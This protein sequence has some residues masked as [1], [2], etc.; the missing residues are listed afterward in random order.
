M[1]QLF[2]IAPLKGLIDI[3][4]WLYKVTQCPFKELINGDTQFSLVKVSKGEY[5]RLSTH[6]FPQNSACV[7]TV[8]PRILKNSGCRVQSDVLT[9]VCISRGFPLP[10]IKWPLLKHHTEYSVIT[11]VSKHTVNCTVTLTVKDHTNTAVECVSSNE[12][13]EVKQNFTIQ[14]DMSEQEGTWF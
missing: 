6:L 2:L 9:C 5:K 7:L 4:T 1:M 11:T 3:C 10:T 14:V 12:Y 8:F 13:R